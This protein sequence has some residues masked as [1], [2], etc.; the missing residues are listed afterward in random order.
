MNSSDNLIEN[1]LKTNNGQDAIIE[2]DNLLSPIFY[3]NPNI[4]S[5]PEK[6]IVL[7]EELEREINSGGFNSLFFNSP[8]NYSHEILNALKTI[9][10]TI[11]FKIL[12]K[13]I[14]LFPNGEVPKDRDKRQKMLE[15]IEDK[16]DPIWD[17]LDEM[18]FNYEEDIY[19]IMIE[20]ITKNLKDFR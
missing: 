4:L 5:V 15:K 19:S 17:E 1:I 8:G 12:E 11:F 20:Y 2:I 14:A 7:I 13:A 18:F 16:A 6:N 9:G 3:K 10:S